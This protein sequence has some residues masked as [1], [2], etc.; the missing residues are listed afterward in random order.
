[1]VL[2]TYPLYSMCSI[3]PSFP[4]L[5]VCEVEIEYPSIMSHDDGQDDVLF[6]DLVVWTRLPTLVCACLGI[7]LQIPTLRGGA[8][9]SANK[10]GYYR[11]LRSRP[12]IGVCSEGPRAPFWPLY[13][14]I[15]FNHVDSTQYHERQLLLALIK[16]VSGKK[17][18]R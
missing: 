16:Y 18:K 4:R 6:F 3:E 12:T 5:R 1:M 17:K 13:L 2:L 10:R 11:T 7:R 14:T 9:S 8:W 15:G